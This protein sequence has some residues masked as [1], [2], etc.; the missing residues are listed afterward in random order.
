MNA[1]A[2]RRVPTLADVVRGRAS[3][4][5]PRLSST[6]SPGSGRR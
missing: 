5:G 2:H 1:Q 4:I 3:L 6:T